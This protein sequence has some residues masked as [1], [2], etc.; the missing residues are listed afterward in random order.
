MIERALCRPGRRDGG[1][2]RP[3]A[4]PWNR[5]HRHQEK[6]VAGTT[7][8]SGWLG[9]YQGLRW[10]RLRRPERASMAGQ[11]GNPA[12]GP[13]YLH[14][15]QRLGLRCPASSRLPSSRAA[16]PT[17]LTAADIVVVD[18]DSKVVEEY[19]AT[20]FRYQDARRVVSRVPRPRR[21]RPHA[22]HLRD[23]LGAGLHARSRST[24]PP[25]PT[26]SPKTSP[27]RP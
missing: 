16:S 25:T 2:A 22:L 4:Q 3:P 1:R 10:N 13:R 23:G 21:D 26:T 18:L 19:L 14:V 5:S 11:H 6:G 24:A 15:R 8:L 7:L 9:R 17:S 12:P 20:F 27:V